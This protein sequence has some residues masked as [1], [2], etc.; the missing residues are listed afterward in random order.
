[1][2]IDY[3]YQWGSVGS[4]TILDDSIYVAHRQGID[5]VSLTT[6]AKVRIISSGPYYSILQ[7][8]ILQTR[9]RGIL[10]QTV[11]HHSLKFH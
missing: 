2:A 10:C 8:F 3:Q 11:R 9:S 4:M 7:H 6:L 1:M 5:K